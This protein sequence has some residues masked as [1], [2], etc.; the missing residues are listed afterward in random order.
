VVVPDLT[1]V[2][3]AN[4]VTS[5]GASVI[6]ADVEPDTLCL[7]ARSLLARPGTLTERTKV[8]V[9]VALNNRARDLAGLVAFAHSRG[10]R[11]LEDSAQSVGAMW[12]GQHLGTLGDLGTFSFSSPKI[13]STGQGGAVVVPAHGA[14]PHDLAAALRRLKNFGR[15]GSG[16]DNYLAGKAL[17]FKFTDMAAALGRVQVR[18][19][20]GRVQRMRQIWAR[21]DRGLQ[22]VRGIRLGPGGDLADESNAFADPG[23]IPWFID[24]FIGPADE[25]GTGGTVTRGATTGAG[26]GAVATRAALQRWLKQHAVGTRPMYPSLSTQAAFADHPDYAPP[27]LESTNQSSTAHRFPNSL[28][29]AESGLFLPS[30]STLT[31]GQVD[32][33]CALIRLFFSTHTPLTS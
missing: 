2:A 23:W 1:M 11:V 29:A 20:P 12:R 28:A 15:A 24:A 32:H 6:F 22:G 13:I 4:A 14:D 8:V 19:L 7:S 21:Y 10:L 33:V 26:T 30:S 18:K 31:D 3:T 16:A 27:P 5:I 9:F 25:G 17:N